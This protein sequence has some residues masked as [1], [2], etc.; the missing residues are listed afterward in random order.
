MQKI[1]GY[2]DMEKFANNLSVLYPVGKDEMG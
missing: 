2:Y 1:R